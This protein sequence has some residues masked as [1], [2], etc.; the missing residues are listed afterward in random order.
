MLKLQIDLKALLD[1]YSLR[2]IGG[3]RCDITELSQFKITYSRIAKI[4][5]DNAC[6]EY[7]DA[8]EKR[9]SEVEA[10]SLAK[11][12]YESSLIECEK[13]ITQ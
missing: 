10:E 11:Q 9:V 6:E 2:A 5:R 3:L 7:A 12:H 1:R 13:T 8:I 4:L